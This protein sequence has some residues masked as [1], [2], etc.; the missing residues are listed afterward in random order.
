MAIFENE[1]MIQKNSKNSS[2]SHFRQ[3][4]FHKLKQTLNREQTKLITNIHIIKIIILHN[5]EH[6]HVN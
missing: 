6:L 5:H 4:L 2:L 3:V 1:N